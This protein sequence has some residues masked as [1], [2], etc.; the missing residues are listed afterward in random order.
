MG[1]S[2]G[3]KKRLCVAAVFTIVLAGN[4]YAIDSDLTRKTLVGITGLSVAVE[5]LQPNVRK[6]ATRFGLEREQLQ[7]DIEAQLTAAGIQILN[8]EKWAQTSGRP[9]LY[10]NVNTHLYQKYWY[11]YTVRVELRQIAT[12]EALPDTKTLADTWSIDMAGTAN[13]GTLNSIKDNV[14]ALVQKFI[15]AYRSVNKRDSK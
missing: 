11:S 12:L 3:L 10:V 4:A 14:K 9:V 1:L 5:E 7:A 13:I 6:Y 8:K 2:T 15:T